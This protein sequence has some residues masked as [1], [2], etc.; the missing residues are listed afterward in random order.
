[1]VTALVEP[2]QRLT[3][4]QHRQRRHVPSRPTRGSRPVERPAERLSRI[5]GSQHDRVGDVLGMQQ[6]VRR[7]ACGTQPIDC[8]GHGELSRPETVNEVATAN[9]APL[10]EHLQ[11]P[12]D[13]G[14][15]SG[16]A[17]GQDRLAGNHAVPL[18]HLQCLCM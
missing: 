13:A 11:Y 2:D 1:M 15:A 3:G 9:L 7:F 10:F 5:G 17:L 14:E 12:I 8:A 16:D 6:R 4:A 18:N